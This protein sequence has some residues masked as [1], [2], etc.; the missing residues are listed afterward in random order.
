[1]EEYDINNSYDIDEMTLDEMKTY[2]DEYISHMC[3]G[4]EEIVDNISGELSDAKQ[5]VNKLIKMY[6]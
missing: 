6:K 5:V 4:I 3:I 2:I 1:L